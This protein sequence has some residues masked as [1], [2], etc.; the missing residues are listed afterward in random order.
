MKSC[1]RKT[2]TA[3]LKKTDSFPK[4]LDSSKKTVIED[5]V[6]KHD[7]T[8]DYNCILWSNGSAGKR[9]ESISNIFAT[10]FW[11]YLLIKLLKVN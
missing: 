7:E 6:L 9:I 8:P 10:R 1:T 5:F 3:I 4:T 11:T 2:G